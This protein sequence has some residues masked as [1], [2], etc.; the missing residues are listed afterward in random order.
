[1]QFGIKK[2]KKCEPKGWDVGSARITEWGNGYGDMG[3]KGVRTRGWI[4]WE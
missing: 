3:S 1:M 2:L 4:E